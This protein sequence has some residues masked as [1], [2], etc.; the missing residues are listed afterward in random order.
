MGHML[1]ASRHM[2]HKRA[3]IPPFKNVTSLSDHLHVCHMTHH[4][5]RDAVFEE[6]LSE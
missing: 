1:V 5:A 6:Y 3:L 2:I 4:M